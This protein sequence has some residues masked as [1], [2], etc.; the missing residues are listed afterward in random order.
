ME[1]LEEDLQSTFVPID[2][3][4]PELMPPVSRSNNLL[5]EDLNAAAQPDTATSEP[6][7]PKPTPPT[8]RREPPDNR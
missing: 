2:Q 7:N 3:S 8:P 1:E 4:F 5:N 6:P